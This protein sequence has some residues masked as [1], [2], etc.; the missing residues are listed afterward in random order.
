MTQYQTDEAYFEEAP[1]ED[2][3]F[4]RKRKRLANRQADFY[5]VPQD[6]K[7]VE[8]VAWIVTGS[9]GIVLAIGTV[10]VA[11]KDP[12]GA[13][14]TMVVPLIYMLGSMWVMRRR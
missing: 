13:G 7:A 14:W 5:P 8:I 10:I 4:D 9:V 6:T 1:Q 11:S 3:G 2:Y 12:A